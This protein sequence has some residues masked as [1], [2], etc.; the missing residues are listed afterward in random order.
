LFLGW[1]TTLIIISVIPAWIA[2]SKGLSFWAWWVYAILLFPIALI[3]SVAMGS[4]K[5]ELEKRQLQSGYKKCPACAELIKSEAKICKHCGTEQIE[6][7]EAEIVSMHTEGAFE[8][9]KD[10]A[11]H[12]IPGGFSAMGS[13]FKSIEKARSHID[14]NK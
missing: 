1:I 3:H 9:Y 11:I 13:W 7:P 8:I 12:E 2:Q 14:K 10:E 4:N 6:V 5:R